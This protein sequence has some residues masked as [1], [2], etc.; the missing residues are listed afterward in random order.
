M[1]ED[2]NEENSQPNILI[3][4]GDLVMKKK[5]SFDESKNV[6]KEFAKNEQIHSKLS[7]EKNAFTSP[8][9][10]SSKKNNKSETK[11]EK[12]KTEEKEET[13]K[14]PKEASPALP[15]KQMTAEKVE[16]ISKLKT[17]DAV[18]KAKDDLL[19]KE[20]PNS[21]YQFERDFKSIKN[22]KERKLNYVMNIKP[23]NFKNIFK[24]DL[25]A[26]IMLQIF[27]TYLDQDNQDEFLKTNS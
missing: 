3:K 12:A 9:K 19:L 20:A 2:E 10:A 17:S 16:S 14:E 4:D 13:P 18:L 23:E 25:E 22:D 11:K 7:Q 27:K 5:V 8:K 1:E 21:F 24:S 15:K 6:I 26:E